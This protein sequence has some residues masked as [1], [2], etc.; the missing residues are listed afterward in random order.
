M[1][2]L[3]RLLGLLPVMLL[4]LSLPPPAAAQTGALY[5]HVVDPSGAVIPGA[6]VKLT[7]GSQTRQIKSTPDGYYSFPSL[8]PGAYSVSVSAKGFALLT[9]P[10]VNIAARQA[11]QLN[12]SMAIAVQNQQVSVEDENQ[13]V[14]L[15]P[16]Q[17]AG[18]TIIKGSALDALSDDPDELKNELQALAGPAAGP[19]GG[20][21]Y[22]DGFEGGQ[23]P[24]KSDILEIR[25]NQNP[26]S[27]EFDR[28]GYGRVEIITKPG[29]QKY[30][31]TLSSYGNS[32]AFNSANPL[33]TQQP[34]YYMW[35]ANANISGP[36]SKSASWFFHINRLDRHD[37]TIINALNPQN[38]SQRIAQAF[39]TPETYLSIGPRIDLQLTKSNLLTLR[40]AYYRYTQTG[41]GVGEFSLSE[42]ASNHTTTF[43]EFQA[44]DTI[45]VS[46]NLVNETRF[47]WDRTSENNTPV[48]L[49]PRIT[50]Q[51]AFTT[52]GSG[53]GVSRNH[54]DL[55]ILQNYSTATAG[56]HAFHF[57]V[58]L[59]AY[60][61]A[62]YSTAGANGS[63]YFNSV[64][65][66]QAGNPAQYSATIINN[67]E[68][69][70]L[71]FDSAIFAQDDWRLKPNFELGLG[72]RFETQNR[73][74]DHADW[75]PRIAFAWS[76]DRNGSGPAKTVIRVGYGWFYD[77]FTVPTGFNSAAG[78]PYILQTIHDNGINEHSYV[79]TNPGF[80]DPNN[81]EPASALASL[82]S[83]VPSYR[84]IDSH[85]HA[86][87]DM[88]GGVGVDR[89][90]TKSVTA[91]LTYL[92]T[93]GV[94]QY[95]T[96]N[97][98]APAFDAESY[99]VTSPP[100]DAYNYQF[101]SGGFYKQHQLIAT[102]SA[103]TK[104]VIVSA[105]YTL[106]HARSDTQGVNYFPSDPQNPGFDYG[107]AAFDFRHRLTLLDSYTAPWGVVFASLFEVQSG[108]P[109]NF[110]IGNDLTGNNQ[111]NARPT[112]GTCGAP[113]VIST[114]YGCL[115]T[116]PA[117]KGETIVPFDLGT[118]PTSVVMH[119]RLSKVIGVGPRI[120]SA[121]SGRTYNAG[122]RS[123]SSRGLS[124]GG[125]AIRLDSAA[126]RRYNL[127]FVA[128]VDNLFNT[129]NYGPPNGV[130]LSPL[131][132]KTLTLAGSG[133]SSPTLGNRSV[134]L[135]TSFTF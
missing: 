89:Q 7:Q 9:V 31:G 62:S 44:G 88:Q 5:G 81:P 32:S 51:G 118:G 29:T 130:L 100:P 132:N 129:A 111:F 40:G 109:Y 80:F 65:A 102:L 22:I 116:N 95:L 90:I 99:T 83:A 8:V 2:R 98:T 39:P 15:S 55:F 37:Q 77:R 11:I 56:P 85:F 127:T 104:Q 91:N 21:I 117:G 36:L 24:P 70:V 135:Q 58:R 17:N 59:R 122:G 48:S 43:G 49:A 72:L 131:F 1:T 101:Q 96:N 53:A 41:A 107:R 66:Y 27:A 26:F 84:T 38:T 52:G 78:T 10:N 97:V 79:V 120:E 57:G 71:L 74:H 68:A 45:L 3:L 19:N 35:G 92:Y 30:H 69:R 108:S 75:A 61:D 13:N 54:Q 42:Q 128:G 63:Y 16:D 121:G 134:I 64:A 28:I 14:G 50:V 105:T 25:V 93:Q 60:R 76:P 125:A 67:P 82:S 124:G 106:N 4:S 94:H 23:I 123:V 112:Y 86:A 110:T 126:P 113:G 133:F 119:A 6:I 47:V 33:I 115:D 114:R 103:R 87:L 46:P 34:S 18:A 73:I 12:L 20:Q